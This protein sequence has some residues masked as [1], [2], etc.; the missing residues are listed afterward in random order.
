MSQSEPIRVMIVDDHAVLREGIH[1]VCLATNDLIL[2]GEAANGE[3]ALILCD[4]LHPDVVLVDLMMPGMNGVETTKAIQE[5]WSEVRILVLTSFDTQDLLCQAI[6]AGAKGYI[7]KNAATEDIIN[8]IRL[9]HRGLTIMSSEVA[10]K[11]AMIPSDECLTPRQLEVL[12]LMVQGLNN[13][14][15]GQTL[16][17]SPYTARFHVSEILSKLGVSNRTEAVALALQHKL[18]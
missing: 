6:K 15:I 4:K 7:L 18:V 10:E 8:A 16:H 3:E 5:Q 13:R 9:V 17:I 1:Y 2:V 14:Q 11:L 12:K